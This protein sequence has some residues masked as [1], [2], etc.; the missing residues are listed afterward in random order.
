MAPFFWITEIISSL[1]PHGLQPVYYKKI[2]AAALASACSQVV[3]Q[4]PNFNK[5]HYK[6]GDEENN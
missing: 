2:G 6:S 5:A 1:D 3:Q 4:I